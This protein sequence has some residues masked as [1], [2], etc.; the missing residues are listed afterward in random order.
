MV[1]ITD[2]ANG[3]TSDTPTHNEPTP[4]KF[5]N[6]IRTMNKKGYKSSQPRHVPASQDSVNAQY[7]FKHYQ[8]ATI[9]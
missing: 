9:L 3:Q 2:K 1:D 7:L 6:P 8:C 5:N 4:P